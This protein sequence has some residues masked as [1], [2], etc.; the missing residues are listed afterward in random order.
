MLGKILGYLFNFIYDQLA[1]MGA[2]PANFSFLAMTIII[3][4][5]IVKLLVL[6]LQIS[7]TKKMKKTADLQPK[8]KEIQ[9]KYGYDQQIASQKVMELYRQEGASITGGCLPLLIQFPI[10]IAFLQVCQNPAI[11]AFGEAKYAAM[12]KA[13]FW[14]KDLSLADPYWYGLPLIA[15]LV[16]LLMSVT[17]PKVG[18]TDQQ[19]SKSMNMMQ[20]FMPLMTFFFTVKYP[21]G[22]AL[23]WAVSSLFA[24]IQQFVQNRIIKKEEVIVSEK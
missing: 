3:S 24:A 22:L 13:F 20:Y 7:S 23:Y 5:I 2:E 16:T 4:T 12:S 15:T 17:T 19:Q 8:V 10:L 1:S 14:I 6:P 11:N 21:A 18:M 9:E